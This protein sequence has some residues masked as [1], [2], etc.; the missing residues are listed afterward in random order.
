[1]LSFKHVLTFF[2]SFCCFL[3]SSTLLLSSFCCFLAVVDA[4]LDVDSQNAHILF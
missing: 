3:R 1:L 4:S 2:V